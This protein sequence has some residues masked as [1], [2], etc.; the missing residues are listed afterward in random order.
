MSHDH[1]NSVLDLF[2]I[3]TKHCS[4]NSSWG[5]CSVDNM[6]NLVR[7]EG[8]HL[9]QP[10]SNFI[11]EDHCFQSILPRVLTAV[12][13]TSN[14]DRIVVV[15]PEFSLRSYK[16]NLT[17]LWPSM[18][19]LYPNTVPFESHSLTAEQ[20]AAMAFS[21]WLQSLVPKHLLMYMRSILPTYLK[22]RVIT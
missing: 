2:R 16:A 5:Y 15:V 10:S 14:D 20:L 8:E 7:L 17:A 19:G 6:I 18:E 11:N 22:G 1:S 3:S 4:I 9:S 12:L 13:A 21:E